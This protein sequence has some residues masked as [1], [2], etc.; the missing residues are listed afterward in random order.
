MAARIMP[1]AIIVVLAATTAFATEVTYE[2]N[3][4]TQLTATFSAPG[5]RSPGS[6]LLIFAGS[7]GAAWLPQVRSA[8]GGRYAIQNTEFWIKGK[9]ATLTRSGKS[10]NCRTN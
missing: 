6:V 10:E 7:R 5:Q 2:C 3:G 8:D 4:G 9:E 1:L